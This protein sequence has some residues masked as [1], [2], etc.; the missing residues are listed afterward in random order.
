M[1]LFKKIV[2]IALVAY[3]LVMMALLAHTQWKPE[4]DGAAI[5]LGGTC[6]AMGLAKLIHDLTEDIE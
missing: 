6:F 5:V 1:K 2:A 4:S 3:P